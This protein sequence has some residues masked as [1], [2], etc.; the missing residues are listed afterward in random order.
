MARFTITNYGVIELNHVSWPETARVFGQ[1]PL[2]PTDFAST[3]A[4]NGM[5]L[6]YDVAGGSVRFAN[7]ITE[8]VGVLYMGEKEYNQFEPGLN[9]YR[10]NRGEF[11]PRIGMPQVGD[12]YTTNTF[13]YTAGSGTGEFANN[14]AVVAALEGNLAS[15]PL[16][17]IPSTTEGAPQ[18]TNA[19][20]LAAATGVA[21]VAQVVK[22]YTLP[23]GDPA[24]KVQFTKVA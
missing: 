24:I 5:W 16:Y 11:Y 6:A 17:L 20:G 13:S 22:Y 2:D 23:N 18:L 12:I 8:P 14:A 21:T 10:L 9:N 1:L 4:E 3:P 7:A 19:A 15:A